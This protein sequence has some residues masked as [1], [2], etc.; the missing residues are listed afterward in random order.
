M[1]ENN[2]FLKVIGIFGFCN[3]GKDESFLQIQRILYEAK[4]IRV[5]RIALADELKREFCLETGLEFEEL[6]KNKNSYR[7]ELQKL[8]DLRKKENSNYWVDKTYEKLNFLCVPNQENYFV[9]TDVR[10][11]N[12]YNFLKS[13]SL[14]T[15]FVRIHRPSSKP[16]NSHSSETEWAYLP[17]DYILDNYKDKPHLYGEWQKVLFY[18]EWLRNSFS[19]VKTKNE[20]S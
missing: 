17:V 19:I 9:F 14:N 12:E 18:F 16:F 4:K 11:K 8:A 15:K 10:Y 5:H 3:S 2:S 6:E 20:D 1:T 13:V 7:V